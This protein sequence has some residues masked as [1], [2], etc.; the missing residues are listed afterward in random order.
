[1]TAR[2]TSHIDTFVLDHLPPADLQPRTDWSGVAEVAYPLSLNAATCLLDDWIARGHGDRPALHHAGGAWSYQ[3]LYETANRI[4]HVLVKDCGLVPGGRVLLRSS[5]QPMLVACWFAVI[6]AGGVAVTTMPLLRLR[7][8]GDII[9]TARVT[10]AIADAPVAGD[11]EDALGGRERARLLRFNAPGPDGLEALSA[12]RSATFKNVETMGADPAI[13][14]FTSGTTGRSKGTVHGHR[15]LIATTDTYARYV[16]A[17]AAD[18]VFIGTPPIA[19]TYALGGLVLFPMRFGASTALLEQATPAHLLEGIQ[20]FGATIAVTSPTAYRAML[21]QIGEFDLRSLRKCVSAGETLPAATFNAWRKA[22]GIRLMDGIGSTEMLH[23]FVGS[24]PDETRPGSTG[25]VVPGYTAKVVDDDGREVM[26]GTVGRLAVI[27]PTGCRYLDNLQSQRKYVQHGW[28][29]TGDAYRQDED[30][31]F[32]Y[33]SRTDDMIITSGYNVSGV[34]VENV[35]LTHASV[36]EC[37]VIGAPDEARGQ[38]VTAFIVTAA[39][40]SGSEPLARELQDFVKAELAPYKYP[41]AI[42]FVPELPRTQTG[43][44]QR[45]RLR[46]AAGVAVQIHEPAGWPKPKGY[47]NAVS[48]SGRAVFVAGQI[49]WDPV[50]LAFPAA[51]FAG[52]VRQALTNVVTALEAAGARPDQ[53]TRLTWYIVDR[54]EYLR[55]QREIGRAYRDVIGRHFPA[56]SVV[57]V[58]GLVE[59]TARVEIEATAVVGGDDR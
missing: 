11:L 2:A 10:L 55:S 39:G 42:E 12:T 29:L 19:F 14:A 5:N 57:I 46:A 52:E 26:R 18:D 1:M 20:R 22:T 35:L 24:P 41:R 54:D 36:A 44:L 6:K 17:P 27:G 34:E 32:W 56:M 28:N 4:A 9:Q 40:V 45:Y 33:V 48:A 23:I 31:Y 47:A 43:K 21:K 49:G 3:R 25:K 8:L 51:D 16:L 58:S 7:E 13:L 50:T 15:D 38:L 37:A 53:I 59:K 30:D